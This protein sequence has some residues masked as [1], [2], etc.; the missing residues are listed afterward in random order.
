M[1]I[2]LC[3]AFDTFIIAIGRRDPAAADL[4][5]RC[6]FSPAVI[7][8]LLI[9]TDREVSPVERMY[10]ERLVP[11]VNDPADAV[12]RVEGGRGTWVVLDGPV[13]VA[14]FDILSKDVNSLGSCSA[15][16]TFD[17]SPDSI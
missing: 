14:M 1:N 6:Y 12:A 10:D 16:V 7:P 17:E 4:S 3:T 8:R 15:N 2:S 13:V 5:S 11:H 9:S